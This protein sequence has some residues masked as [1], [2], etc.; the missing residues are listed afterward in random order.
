MIIKRLLHNS[1]TRSINSG[2]I[3][4][5]YGARQTGK[6]TLSKDVLAEHT[7]KKTL[8]ISADEKR[9]RDVL[10]SQDSVVLKS[11]IGN[12]EIVFIDEAQRVPDIGLNLKIIH[13]QVPGVKILVTGSSSFDLANKIKEPLTGRTLTYVLYPLS[14]QE[15]RGH[16]SMIDLESMLENILIYGLYPD[17]FL[18][19]GNEDKLPRLK[20][21]A[22]SYVYKDV[23]EVSG[24]KNS[25]K[26]EDLLRL[27][28]YQIG[29]EVSMPELGERLGM[30]KDTVEKY[31]SILENAF[32]VFRLS[33]FSRNLRNEI[34]KMNKIY[35][36][37]TG[38]RN[39]LIGDM[40]P[41]KL[42]NDAGK[43]W[44]NFLIA[45]RKKYIEY[46]RLES[47][48]YFW[49]TYTNVEIDY[50]EE[51]EG[52]VFA[53]EFKFSPRKKTKAP[54]TWIQAYP[55]SKFTSIDRDNFWD[56]TGVHR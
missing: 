53:Y 33:G 4:I 40:K 34:T 26:V 1:I 51:T 22:Q 38:L 37:D 29:S 35:F 55:D 21:L 41:L 13:D 9:F 49:R 16:Y 7:D 31:I 47:K 19:V 56:F 2:K 50:I 11:L 20:E 12:A 3:L 18:Q 43:I 24:I 23:L 30:S 46:N 44:E 17:I 27:L 54:S 25:S 6:T 5:L 28:A 10:S 48:G 15:L 45:E 8:E 36:Y 14:L 39:V 42:R 52:Q 32:I